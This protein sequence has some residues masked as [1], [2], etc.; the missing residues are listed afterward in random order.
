HDDQALERL[1][2]DLASPGRPHD[3]DAHAGDAHAA[4]ARERVDQPGSL[5]RREHGQ[6]P[7]SNRDL[8][9]ADELNLGV[10]EVVRRSGEDRADLVDARTLTILEPDLGAAL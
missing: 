6:R 10:A 3:L 5:R 4:G 7:R 1:A 9:P 2:R 8:V